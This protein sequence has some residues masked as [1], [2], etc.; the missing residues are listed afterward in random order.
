MY[1]FIFD[2]LIDTS[3]NRYFTWVLEIIASLRTNSEKK[4]IEKKPNLLFGPLRRDQD[5]KQH[6]PLL[7]GLFWIVYERWILFFSTPVTWKKYVDM[8]RELT[9]L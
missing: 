5:W 3:I 7:Y 4:C 9:L 2:E 6:D 1:T 8:S